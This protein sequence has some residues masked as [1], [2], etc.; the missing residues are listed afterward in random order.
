MAVNRAPPVRGGRDLGLLSSFVEAAD[1]GS[2]TEAA[3][4]LALTP[5]TISRNIARIE[6][7]LGIRLFNRTT[8]ALDL[9]D[10]GRLYLEG[11][12]AALSLLEESEAMLVSAGHQP[13][14]IL[15]VAMPVPFG[16]T[17]ALPRLRDFLDANERISL[18]L[19]FEDNPVD[20]VRDGYD[21]VIRN[22]KPLE[23]NHIIRKLCE[24]RQILVASPRYLAEHGTP[25]R[26]EDLA[27][28]LCI[29]HRS[30]SSQT[31]TW[32]LQ[33]LEQAGHNASHSVSV[34]HDP[35]TRLR[36]FGYYHC[37]ID[38][39]LA[40]LGIAAASYIHAHNLLRERRLEIVM[41]DFKFIDQ[42]GL[43]KI[44]AVYPDRK[45]LPPKV[46]VFID[47][48]LEAIHDEEQTV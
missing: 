47:F 11:V 12:K 22:G 10:D 31:Y 15:R 20:P 28:H 34:V 16:I 46:R 29:A 26:P 30:V 8:R 4:R 38:A 36:V 3:R 45:F 24:E 6:E 32:N 21:L 37:G 14:G 18:E 7:N 27:Q 39:A 43:T 41:P 19:T 35:H 13:S 48:L 44:Y 25:T 42:T 9:T 23:G 5:A 33:S 17:Y 1:C 40:G 2:F